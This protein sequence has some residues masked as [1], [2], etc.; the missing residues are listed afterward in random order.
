MRE[1]VDDALRNAGVAHLLEKLLKFGP[2]PAQLAVLD[3]LQRACDFGCDPLSVAPTGVIPTLLLM[4]QSGCQEIMLEC[5]N[6]LGLLGEYP[7]HFP[8]DGI[9]VLVELLGCRCDAISEAAS[10]ALWGFISSAEHLAKISCEHGCLKPLIAQLQNKKI[11]AQFPLFCLEV[12]LRVA[13]QVAAAVELGLLPI[14]FRCLRDEHDSCH[15]EVILELLQACCTHVPQALLQET[16]TLRKATIR[17]VVATA[18]SSRGSNRS[19][20][21][22]LLHL[23]DH[24]NPQMSM[25]IRQAGYREHQVSTNVDAA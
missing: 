6:V 11:L 19:E 9:P 17:K 16:A 22:Q 23:L 13:M 4:A 20:A 21:M 2:A 25:L 1:Q 14:L 10:S 5:L 24:A 3:A 18:N 7:E 15:I 8:D 12:A